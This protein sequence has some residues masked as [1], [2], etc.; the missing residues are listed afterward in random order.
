MNWVGHVARMLNVLYNNLIFCVHFWKWGQN[1][2]VV[3]TGVG[4][5][6]VDWIVLAQDKADVKPAIERRG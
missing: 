2:T 4:L 5:E 1:I 6:S 3:F